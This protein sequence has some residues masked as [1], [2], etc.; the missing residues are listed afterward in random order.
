MFNAL[1]IVHPKKLPCG[2]FFSPTECSVHPTLTMFRSLRY[3]CENNLDGL[4]GLSPSGKELEGTDFWETSIKCGASGDYV[5]P[6]VDFDSNVTELPQCLPRR[7]CV[8]HSDVKKVLETLRPFSSK[9]PVLGRHE[10]CHIR[11]NDIRHVLSEC[12][13]QNNARKLSRCCND[14]IFGRSRAQ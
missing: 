12:H 2:T 6:R 9:M 8:T 7:K 11:Q 3:I 14:E 13:L 10:G 4:A 5:L 1:A